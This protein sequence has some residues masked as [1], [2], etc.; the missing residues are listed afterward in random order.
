M[1]TVAGADNPYSSLAIF[2]QE[3]LA[4][5]AGGAVYVTRCVQVEV[6][7]RSHKNLTEETSAVYNKMEVFIDPISHTLSQQAGGK[8]VL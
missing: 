8:V 3:H 1:E 7:P 5:K 4:V 6:V 2:R